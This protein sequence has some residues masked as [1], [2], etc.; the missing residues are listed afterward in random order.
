MYDY[1]EQ[2][3]QAPFL[4]LVMTVESGA[5]AATRIGTAKSKEHKLQWTE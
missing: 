1:W 4:G 3:Q 2:E 5:A